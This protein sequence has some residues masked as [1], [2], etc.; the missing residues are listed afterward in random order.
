MADTKQDAINYLDVLKDNPGW[1]IIKKALE[2]NI[3]QIELKLHG[4]MDLEKNENI[5]TL[6]SEWR[7]LNKMKNLPEELI[8]EYKDKEVFPSELDPYP[9]RDET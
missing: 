5:E 9:Q 1:I 7:N 4:E 3:R 2:A 6:Q 8:A